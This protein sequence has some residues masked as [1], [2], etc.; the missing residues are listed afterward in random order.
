MGQF[1]KLVSQSPSIYDILDIFKF[2]TVALNSGIFFRLTPSQ[3][4]W[5]MAYLQ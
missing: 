4:H 1:S 5:K 2:Q 3:K